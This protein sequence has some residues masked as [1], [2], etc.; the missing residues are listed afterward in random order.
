MADAYDGMSDFRLIRYGEGQ[1]LIR[2][3]QSDSLLVRPC[4]KAE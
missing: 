2:Q 1:M 3:C 4:M